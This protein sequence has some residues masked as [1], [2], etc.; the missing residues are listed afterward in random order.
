MATNLIDGPETKDLDDP[1]NLPGDL[2]IDPEFIVRHNPECPV[3]PIEE[4]PYPNLQQ[5]EE[6]FLTTP[7]PIE[8]PVF[9]PP[10]R[11]RGDNE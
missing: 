10:E 11:D 5:P 7:I 6:P 8:E 1:S 3:D 9:D 2:S 4:V